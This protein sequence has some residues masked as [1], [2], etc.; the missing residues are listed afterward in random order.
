MLNKA[1]VLV[2]LAPLPPPFGTRTDQ[3]HVQGAL[4]NEESVLL[5]AVFSQAF[6]VVPGNDHERVVVQPQGANLSMT[7]P[8][9][10]ST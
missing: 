3:R 6:T 10:I 8:I 4:I 2:N 5:L 1:C 9:D 7:L